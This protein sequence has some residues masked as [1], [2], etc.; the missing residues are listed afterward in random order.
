MKKSQETR[1]GEVGSRSNTGRFV[2]IADFL[3]SSSEPSSSNSSSSTMGWEPGRWAT[4]FRDGVPGSPSLKGSISGPT[5][6]EETNLAVRLSIKEA[7][8]TD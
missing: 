6:F 2:S 1:V 7:T 8:N 5:L 3:L 4:G